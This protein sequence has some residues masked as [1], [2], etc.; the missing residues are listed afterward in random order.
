M[1]P[2]S[3]G[4]RCH[5]EA[6]F[7]VYTEQLD[8][9]YCNAVLAGLPKSTIAPLQRAQ[10]AAARLVTGTGPRDHVTPVCWLP[11]QHRITD[12]VCLLMHKIHTKRAS[13]Y[14]IDRVTATAELRSSAGLR[15]ASTSKYQ[16]PRTCI[17]FGERGFSYAGPSAWNTPPDHVQQMTNTITF[18]RH[19]QTVLFRRA[20]PD[21]L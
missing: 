13:S 14:L 17:K 6:S 12:K 11:V 16:T 7:C 4:A 20:F 19:L 5:N 1:S 15:S 21:F 2:S 8:F 9:D 3:V 18:K 10:N